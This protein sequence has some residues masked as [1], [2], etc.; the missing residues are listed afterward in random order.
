MSS[1]AWKAALKAASDAN[2][3]AAWTA[4]GTKT[5]SDKGFTGTPTIVLNGETLD[6]G[7]I[8]TATALTELLKSKGLTS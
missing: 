3:Y 8:G 7:S 6:N 5:F 4:L 1:R 2:T